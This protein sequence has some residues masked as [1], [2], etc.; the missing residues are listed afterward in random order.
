M[1]KPPVDRSSSA[2]TFGG[3][4]VVG[5]VL[6]IAVLIAGYFVWTFLPTTVR[7]RGTDPRIL[8]G[9][10]Y[11]G[12]AIGMIGQLAYHEG[13]IYILRFE[14]SSDPPTGQRDVVL[15]RS[16]RPVVVDGVPGIVYE[17]ETFLVGEL[18]IGGPM[19]GMPR[20]LD[21][22]PPSCDPRQEGRAQFGSVHRFGHPCP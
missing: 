20:P 16:T 3:R 17:G 18:I 9:S 19:G 6:L 11:T 2:A 5:A 7:V 1:V 22:P 12:P 14:Q 21:Q 4:K 8:V 10:V 15:P 13:C